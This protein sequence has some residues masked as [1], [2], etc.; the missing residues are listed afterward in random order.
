MSS[1]G[2][3]ITAVTLFVG[4][5]FTWIVS[6]HYYR[7]TTHDAEKLQRRPLKPSELLKLFQECLD[8]GDAGIHELLGMVAC[9]ECGASSTSFEEEVLGGDDYVTIVSVTCPKCGWSQTAEA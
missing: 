2:I 8:D 1:W 4:C 6:K 3:L 9:P 7:R 5:L